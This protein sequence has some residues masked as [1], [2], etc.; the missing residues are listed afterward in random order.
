LSVIIQFENDDF[1]IIHKPAGL[2]FHGGDGVLNKLR[3]NHTDALGV[4]RLDRGTSGLMLF[5]K[6]KEAQRDLSQLFE[7]KKVRKTYIALSNLK[8][9]KKQGGIKGDLEKSRGGSYKLTRNMVNPSN[10]KF[11]ST[12]F[13][14]SELWGFVLNPLTGKTHQLRVVLKSLGSTIVGDERYNGIDSDRMYL[15]SYSLKFKY[16]GFEYNFEGYPIMGK[17]FMDN[18]AELL[19]F[20][21]LSA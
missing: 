16:K 15:H 19:E 14:S 12:K 1:L 17:L 6:T 20:I 4:H 2:E 13:S 9:R 5:A 8:P 3:I 7:N 11:K 18:K 10:T 21:G